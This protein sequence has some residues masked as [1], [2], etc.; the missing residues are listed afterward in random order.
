[1]PVAPTSPVVKSVR[2]RL[3]VDLQGSYGA[4]ITWCQS[5]G[6]TP[7]EAMR[8]LV[9]RLRPGQWPEDRAGGPRAVPAPLPA[10]EGICERPKVPLTADEA[11]TVAA[12]AK[13]EG[14]TVPRW[15]V[16]LIRAH[17]SG[18]PQLGTP[19]LDALRQ[20]NLELQ[21]LGRS[22]NQI[23]R[24]LNAISDHLEQGRVDQAAEALRQ[25]RGD[26]IRRLISELKSRIDGHLP[27]VSTVLT[28][29]V[30]RWRVAVGPRAG[31]E[32]P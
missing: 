23:A 13:E 1:L 30:E 12:R 15:I 19:S 6:L 14:M 26:E 7:S 27:V 17:L 21:A 32:R 16:S 18:R 3:C 31:R 8:A 10:H 5:M 22:L 11:Q 25:Q 2:H 29:N 28:Q 20:S 4:W 24:A 9:A